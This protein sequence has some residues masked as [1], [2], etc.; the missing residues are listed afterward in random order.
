[1]LRLRT[2]TLQSW[3]ITLDFHLLF[4]CLFAI[5]TALFFDNQYEAVVIMADGAQLITAICVYD[6]NARK[7]SCHHV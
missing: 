6:T 7:P 2:L 1:M 5:F 3:D 4:D